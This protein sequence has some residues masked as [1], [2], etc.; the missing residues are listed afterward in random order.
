MKDK[1]AAAFLVTMLLVLTLAAGAQ[2]QMPKQ[3]D[4]SW[5]HY[6]SGTFKATKVGDDFLIVTSENH[7]PIV[8]DS[9]A[10]PFH[11]LAGRCVGQ[12]LYVKGVGRNQGHCMF[13]DRA[14][15]QW[16]AEFS[17]PAQRLGATSTNGTA[18]FVGGTGKFA[19]ITGGGEYTYTPMRPVA[20]GTY[21]GTPRFKGSYR[22]E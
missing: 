1:L 16:V 18:R 11:E 15:D 17:A 12:V 4:L 8:S 14:G 19:G 7:G 10:G 21:Q 5:N 13:V 3:G 6:L 2:A 9:G 22:L 20:D